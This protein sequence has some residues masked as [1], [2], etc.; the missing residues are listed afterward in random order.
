MNENLLDHFPIASSK[1]APM[2]FAAQVP[3]CW[4]GVFALR[5]CSNGLTISMQVPTRDLKLPA[6]GYQ[7]YL[8]HH[9]VRSSLFSLTTLFQWQFYFLGPIFTWVGKL[10]WIIHICMCSMP[11]KA[12]DG[13][14]KVGKLMCTKYC[15]WKSDYGNLINVMW[16]SKLVLLW[17]G[18]CCHCGVMHWSKHKVGEYRN[19]EKVQL[20]RGTQL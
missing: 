8:L 12:W 20:W 18:L 6:R 9:F 19:M 16:Y 14:G 2:V 10:I 4:S 17:H 7:I 1:L 15:I 13:G 5:K 3:K 11:V